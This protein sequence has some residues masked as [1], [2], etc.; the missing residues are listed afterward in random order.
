M[1]LFL[2][3]LWHFPLCEQTS[4][5]K[6]YRIFLFLGVDAT[7]KLRMSYLFLHCTTINTSMSIF[8]YNLE[9]K[10]KKI[11]SLRIIPK[12]SPLKPPLPSKTPRLTARC[13]FKAHR[14]HSIGHAVLLSP[15]VH[16]DAFE[17]SFHTDSST[18]SG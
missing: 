18:G 7:S 13:F 17:C 5:A 10:L 3:S 12:K 2:V 14:G 1:V 8:I 11:R 16:K 9:I 6:V 15:I 4:D